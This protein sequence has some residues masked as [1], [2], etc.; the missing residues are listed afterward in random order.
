MRVIKAILHAFCFFPGL[1]P[2]HSQL[3]GAIHHILLFRYFSWAKKNRTGR[4]ARCPQLPLRKQ[5]ICACSS[6]DCLG[7]NWEGEGVPG[8]FPIPTASRALNVLPALTAG[9]PPVFI[10]N[11]LIA[12]YPNN[13][14]NKERHASLGVLCSEPLQTSPGTAER[15]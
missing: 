15:R 13:F 10:T 6:G 1:S 2:C 14:T 9:P 5:D 3:R 4:L 12:S 11:S 7:L 8:L